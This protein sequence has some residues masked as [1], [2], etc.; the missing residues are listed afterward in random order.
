M[1]RA[2]V[3]LLGVNFCF[4]LLGVSPMGG[5]S[6]ENS[7]RL[8]CSRPFPASGAVDTAG[9]GRRRLVHPAPV[10]D[11]TVFILHDPTGKKNKG[12]YVNLVSPLTG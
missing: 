1:R 7:R 9:A 11:P 10:G 2:Q 12:A 6:Q 4:P 5:P 8:P 3:E